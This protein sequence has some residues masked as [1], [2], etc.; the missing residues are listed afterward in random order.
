MPT[1]ADLAPSSAARWMTCTASVAF[2]EGVE[3]EDDEW[4][5]EGGDA[6]KK[7]EL[8]LE[9]GVPPTD[10]ILYE[11]LEYA[12]NYAV[13]LESRGFL[14]SFEQIVRYDEDVWGTVD[15]LG[16]RGRSLRIA[17]YKHGYRPVDPQ[18]NAQMATYGVCV[19]AE[20]GIKFRDV[21]LT[22]I[23][24]RIAHIDGPVRKWETD[25]DALEWFRGE[26]ESAKREIRD[27]PQFHAG[28]HCKFCPREGNC[29]TYT[30]WVAKLVTGQAFFKEDAAEDLL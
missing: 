6:H 29:K 14:V 3:R 17:D 7:L 30:N 1:H 20:T 18:Y 12:Y 15:I 9:L 28:K 11:Q 4:N 19:T 5:L 24:P 26:I 10:G 22:V 27:N 13:A 21:E 8:W 2:C 25:G 23:Q 16:T